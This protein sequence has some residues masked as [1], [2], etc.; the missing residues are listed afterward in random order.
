MIYRI[1]GGLGSFFLKVSYAFGILANFRTRNNPYTLVGD[2]DIEWSWISANLDLN[3]KLILDFGPG[4][5][6]TP[7]VAALNGDATVIALD[8]LPNLESQIKW[9]LDNLT[10]K[11]GDIL[12]EEVK[13]YLSLFNFD[14]IINCS[15][16]E[17][18]GLSG[19]YESVEDMDGDLKTMK[20]FQELMSGS[21]NSNMI[22]TI[23]VG[24]DAVIKPLHRV[25]GPIRLRQLLH[26]YKVKKQK[27]MG[28]NQKGYWEEINE[29]E[30]FRTESTSS[31][32]SL[33]LFV[34]CL[35]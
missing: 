21:T 23:P 14:S 19:R 15:T 29:D 16:I 31:Y 2:R 24:K 10:Y 5:S 12:S 6:V 26:G 17:H 8:Q 34:L 18:V 30:A 20:F 27:Y 11:C 32:Y 7:L 4:T 9:K 3:K 22:L 1:F 33:G 25:Y 35:E 13:E 28:K